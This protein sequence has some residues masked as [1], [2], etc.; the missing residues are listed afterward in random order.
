MYFRHEEHHSCNLLQKEGFYMH[1]K[2]ILLLIVLVLP[3]IFLYRYS[4][5]IFHHYPNQVE[6]IDHS[7][8]TKKHRISLTV[9]I[10]SY[11]LLRCCN[12]LKVDSI[13]SLDLNSSLANNT[14]VSSS[15]EGKYTWSMRRPFNT[16]EGSWFFDAILPNWSLHNQI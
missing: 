3:M 8:Q 15:S 7:F 9:Q 16:S 13:D 10:R 4:K 2:L 1:I 12:C 5:M 14:K 6:E 11:N